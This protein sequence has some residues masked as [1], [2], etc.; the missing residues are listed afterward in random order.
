MSNLP[1]AGTAGNGKRRKYRFPSRQ[2]AEEAFA[3]ADSEAHHQLRL[4][5]ALY[6]N[7]VKWSKRRG[8][9]RVGVFDIGK[10]AGPRAVVMF[11]PNTGQ[12]P[13]LEVYS[14]YGERWRKMTREAHRE[15]A[16]YDCVTE[17]LPLLN[18]KGGAA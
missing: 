14:P 4:A 3:R 18:G 6:Q 8:A 7:A 15:P 1:S 13:S 12:E 10:L 17:I 9:Y 2:E 16:L 5:R 11:H